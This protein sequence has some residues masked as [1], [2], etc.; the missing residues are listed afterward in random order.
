ME[1]GIAVVIILTLFVGGVSYLHAQEKSTAF[2]MGLSVGIP[3]VSL[4]AAGLVGGDAAGYLALA[5]FGVGPSTGHFY[6]DQWGR[7]LVFSGLRC[8]IGCLAWGLSAAHAGS[9]PGP[10]V[11]F[12]YVGGMS[13]LIIAIIDIASVPSSVRKYNE[14]LQTTG[15]LDLIPRIDPKNERYGISIVYRF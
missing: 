12:A 1:R 8:G 6:A 7:G 15:R 5:G 11:A 4:A 13:V 14:S 10:E 2:A 9:T 3:L